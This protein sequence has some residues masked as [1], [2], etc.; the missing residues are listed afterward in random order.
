MNL[1]G[2]VNVDARKGA[3]EVERLTLLEPMRLFEQEGDAF[4][5][6]ASAQLGEQLPETPGERSR[7]AGHLPEWLDS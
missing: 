4:I 6:I 2:K 1:R 3:R 7:D 5:A